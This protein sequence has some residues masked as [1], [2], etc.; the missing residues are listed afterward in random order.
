MTEHKAGDPGFVR[1]FKPKTQNQYDIDLRGLRV[2]ERTWKYLEAFNLQKGDLDPKVFLFNPRP[3]DVT[4]RVTFEGEFTE[5]EK[6]EIQKEISE[7]LE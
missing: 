2:S 7:T 4:A 5:Q 6:R 1:E 3:G